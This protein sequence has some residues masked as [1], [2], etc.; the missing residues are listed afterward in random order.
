MPIDDVHQRQFMAFKFEELIV[1]QK[2]I[3]LT[4][5]VN[6]VVEKFPSDERFILL[7]QMQRA[8]DSVALY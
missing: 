2:A 1:W 4:A 5:D 3:D 7:S 6:S 8:A